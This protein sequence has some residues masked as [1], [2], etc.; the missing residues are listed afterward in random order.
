MTIILETE[1]LI[2]REIE[3]SDAQGM[4]ELDSDYD[5]H[6]Y[7]GEPVVNSI[8]ESIEKIKN[9]Q[10][11]YLVNGVGRLAVI[12]KSSNTFLGWAGLKLEAPRPH[13]PEQY[14]DIGY[15]LIKKFWGKGFATEASKAALDYGFKQLKISDIYADVDANNT[16]SKKVLEKMGL[17]YIKSFDDEGFL[18]DWYHI[19]YEL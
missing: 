11:Q 16:A 1:R 18:V 2:L 14:Y 15:R 19:N 10:N 7:L 6:K 13:H 12:E 9:I 3:L 17:K 5:V 4:F 8:E